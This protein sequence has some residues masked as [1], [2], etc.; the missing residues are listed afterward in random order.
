[1]Q[2]SFF[3]EKVIKKEN[4]WMTEKWRLFV[5][6]V[7][8]VWQYQVVNEVETAN[9]CQGCHVSILIRGVSSSGLDVPGIQLSISMRT[10]LVPGARKLKFKKYREWIQLAMISIS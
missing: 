8:K 9:C 7:Q 1:L 3:C 4:V 10:T 2:N 6:V 5:D